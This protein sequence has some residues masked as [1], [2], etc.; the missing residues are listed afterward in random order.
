MKSNSIL[1]LF[2][3]LTAIFVSYGSFAQTDSVVWANTTKVPVGFPTSAFD[4]AGY[5]YGSK[6]LTANPYTFAKMGLYKTLKPVA[7]T[8]VYLPWGNTADT[9]LSIREFAPTDTGMT[10]SL[11]VAAS[12]GAWEGG[13][14]LGIPSRYIEFSFTAS[15][16]FTVTQIVAPIFSGGGTS[17]TGSYFYSTDGVN[18]TLLIS[19]KS[20][21]KISPIVKTDYTLNRISVP[22][23]VINK[24]Q[25]FYF[26]FLP[27]SNSTKTA[28]GKG[29]GFSRIT[30]SGSAGDLTP[31]SF[32]SLIANLSGGQ[33]VINWKVENEINTVS[34]SIEKSI[35]GVDFTTVAS[36]SASKS[37]SY[38][39]ID[40]KPASVNYYRIKSIDA[41]G[42]Y[43]YSS[44]VKVSTLSSAVKAYPNPVVGR[45]LFIEG[46]DAGKYTVNIYN[47]VGQRV[48]SSYL[49]VNG[50][51]QLSLPNSIKAGT[52]QLELSNGVARVVKAIAVQ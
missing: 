28:T 19:G 13:D 3:M 30:I 35:N 21:A 2:I 29:L 40:S 25:T 18:Y 36:V 42:S 47:V 5:N 31:V 41:D 43:Q 45:K 10:S 15:S 46:L 1:R 16:T 22:Y 20:Q 12:V 34:Y 11:P 4:S 38:S 23:V 27:M 8:S 37:G 52:Y 17:C 9:A 24:G 48:S 49:N 14:T 32:G 50:T 44:V 33:S 39:F 7:G 51:S 6:V 26:R